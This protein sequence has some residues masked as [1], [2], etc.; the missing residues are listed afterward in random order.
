MLILLN[1]KTNGLRKSPNT[2]QLNPNV[3]ELRQ[4]IMSMLIYETL[5]LF[6][7]KQQRQYFFFVDY[8]INQWLLVYH[9]LLFPHLG[10]N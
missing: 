7:F 9:S 1:Q 6:R 3:G 5:L 4:N 2:S 10:L 8:R